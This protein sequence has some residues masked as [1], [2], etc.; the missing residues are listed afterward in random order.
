[1]SSCLKSE[2]APAAANSQRDKMKT[3][4]V[5]AKD[6]QRTALCGR[7]RDHDCAGARMAYWAPGP[8]NSFKR[9]VSG[10]IKIFRGD[11]QESV[12]AKKLHFLKFSDPYSY[13]TY[14]QLT[15]DLPH[16]VSGLDEAV[17][18]L[19]PEF[20]ASLQSSRQTLPTAEQTSA[21]AL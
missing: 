2:S 19:V 1:M 14:A 16:A 11:T 4:N 21:K 17:M 9:Q 12:F 3:C 15:E 13:M 18:G 7:R 6:A 20:A 10:D 5:K 8:L